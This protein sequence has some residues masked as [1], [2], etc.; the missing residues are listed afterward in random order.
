M[1][2]CLLLSIHLCA[3]NS[4]NGLRPYLKRRDY[5]DKDGVAQGGRHPPMEH[6]RLKQRLRLFI[7][8][9]SERSNNAE[10]SVHRHTYDD[11]GFCR[12]SLRPFRLV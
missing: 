4:I 8:T 1:V 12:S 2:S 11:S 9:L 7:S 6:E 3:F 10:V 5:R